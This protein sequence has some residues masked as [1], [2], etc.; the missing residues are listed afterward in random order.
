MALTSPSVSLMLL[1]DPTELMALLIPAT[2]L[3]LMLLLTFEPWQPAQL[4]V[5]NAAPFGPGA[6]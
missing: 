4:D 1:I 3:F 6:G 2:D 5:Y